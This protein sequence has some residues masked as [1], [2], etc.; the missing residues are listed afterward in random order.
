MARNAKYYNHDNS[1][2][3][4]HTHERYSHA[5]KSD[6]YQH[7]HALKNRPNGSFS[8]TAGADA[9]LKK[10]LASTN[11]STA[12]KLQTART[13]NGVKFDGSANIE[14]F[15]PGVP[16]PW[17][18]DTPPAGYAIMQGRR[19]IRQH[20]RNWL[21]PILQVLFQ[22]CAAGQSRANP[23]V[24]GPYCLRNRTALNRT[25]T[26]PAHPVRIW[27]RKPHRRLITALNPRITPGRIR[28][29]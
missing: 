29:V 26:A 13:I 22:I 28:T 21:L 8:V 16:L 18:S 3:L 10:P 23:P 1:T 4:A 14:A 2:V 7:P 11:A 5:F 24:A 20:I 17:P 27:G 6:W 12:T 9:R 19:L 25:P 15:P